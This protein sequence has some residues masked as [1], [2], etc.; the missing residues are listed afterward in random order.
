M[1]APSVMGHDQDATACS[2]I[3][4]DTGVIGVTEGVANHVEHAPTGLAALRTTSQGSDRLERPDRP[5][6]D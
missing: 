6:V 5:I 4:G 2:R 3:L 1:V